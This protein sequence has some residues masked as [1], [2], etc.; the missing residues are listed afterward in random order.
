VPLQD[1]LRKMDAIVHIL[2]MLAGTGG[3][4]LSVVLLQTLGKNYALV[5]TPPF[6]VL[7]AIC[8]RSVDGLD[9]ES[10]PTNRSLEGIQTAQPSYARAVL[11]A[12]KTFCRATYRGA[13]ICLTT[14]KFIWLPLAYS[15]VW[16]PSRAR[17]S[18]PVH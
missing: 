7:A 3:A 14:R 15:C 10:K 6:F 11:G 8:W 17:F 18:L 16:L 5:A 12:L 1:K 2:Y 4:F 9:H 13:Q